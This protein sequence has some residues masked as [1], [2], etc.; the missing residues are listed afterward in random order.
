M[1]FLDVKK[2]F[3]KV[4]KFR[5]RHYLINIKIL[6]NT[7]AIINTQIDI[8]TLS[9][10]QGGPLPPPLLHLFIELAQDQ[11]NKLYLYTDDILLYIKN[12]SSLLPV[13][14]DLINSY[15]DAS[16]YSVEI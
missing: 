10:R 4:L 9:F 2:A 16:G 5:F 15:S 11:K 12:P 1:L 6:S 8:I 14:S 13:V 7:S 3:N